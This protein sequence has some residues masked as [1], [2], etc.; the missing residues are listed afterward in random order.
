MFPVGRVWRKGGGLGEGVGGVIL[1]VLTTWRFGI[2]LS[3]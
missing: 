2:S 3:A 1:R